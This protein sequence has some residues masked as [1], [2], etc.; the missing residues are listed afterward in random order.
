MPRHR[1]NPDAEA[2][3]YIRVPGHLKNTIASAA[4]AAGLSITA[5]CANA[6]RLALLD[7]RGIPRPPRAH[8]PLPTVETVIAAYARGESVLTPCGRAGSCP[9][10]EGD[11]EVLHGVEWCGSCGI[12]LV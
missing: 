12:R 1:H 2:V 3:L 11:R 10:V 4:D 5:W 8:A 7:E 9:G 6:L